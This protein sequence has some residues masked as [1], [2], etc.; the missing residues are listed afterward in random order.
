MLYESTFPI[1]HIYA[2]KQP[3]VCPSYDIILGS[4]FN[5]KR[6]MIVVE[7]ESSVVS[8]PSISSIL[9]AQSK[10]QDDKGNILLKI[11]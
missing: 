11:K 8:K 10:R 3:R 6:V 1:F 4:M 7:D 5:D 2:H 9:R